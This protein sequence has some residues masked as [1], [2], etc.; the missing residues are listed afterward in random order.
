MKNLLVRSLSGLIYIC[1]II[2]LLT[3]GGV[4]GFPALCCLFALIGAIELFHIADA[5][6]GFDVTMGLDIIAVG[7]IAGMP[8]LA[9]MSPALPSCLIICILLF[10]FILQLYM[11]SSSP[12]TRLS[13]SLLA[14]IYV[15]ASLA[16]TSYLYMTH[17]MGLLLTMFAMIWMNDTGAYLVGCSIGRHRL[18]PR[19]SPKKSWEGFFG[20]VLFSVAVALT[21]SYFAP[22]IVDAFSTLQLVLVGVVVSVFSTWGDLVESMFK[23][24]ANVKDSGKIM[25]GHGGILDRIDSLLFVGPALLLLTIIFN[26]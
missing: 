8:I 25:P 4:Y 12:A 6:G 21:V 3:L 13:T 5:G 19:I 15:G 7:V 22:E 26:F 9:T 2:G 14:Y 10:R 18:F 23:R 11:H 20:G 16:S 1:V 24:A 17:G